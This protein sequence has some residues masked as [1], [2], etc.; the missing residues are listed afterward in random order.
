MNEPD[1]EH[2]IRCQ[3]LATDIDALSGLIATAANRSRKLGVAP[4]S[5]TS[6]IIRAFRSWVTEFADPAPSEAI[7]E[8]TTALR[9]KEPDSP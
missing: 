6:D 3:E 7:A 4:P 9:G 8:T 5:G 1:R 2:A